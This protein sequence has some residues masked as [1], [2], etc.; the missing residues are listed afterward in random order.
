MED[1]RAGDQVFVLDEITGAIRADRISINLHLQDTGADYGGVT[2]HHG[3]GQLSVTDAHVVILNGRPA[4][5]HSARKGDQLEVVEA[6]EWCGGGGTNGSKGTKPRALTTEQS[7]LTCMR[8]MRMA[9]VTVAVTG[10]SRWKGGIINP[11]THSGRILAATTTSVASSA[12]AAD[13]AD[14]AG[15]ALGAGGDAT[16]A[17]FTLATT[18]IDSPGQV[19]LAVTASPSF[20]KLGSLLFPDQFQGSV[21]VERSIM[22]VCGLTSELQLFLRSTFPADGRSGILASMCEGAAWVVGALVFVL[23]DF[24]VGGGFVVYHVLSE[25][26]EAFWFSTAAW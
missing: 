2:L 19:Q 7:K 22:V 21:L 5:A 12:L 23:V 4:P 6:A 15:Q 20:L 1:L 9:I 11:L 14:A 8:Q 13:A 17:G 10:I 16:F 24:C 18:V 3:K 26:K 25:S